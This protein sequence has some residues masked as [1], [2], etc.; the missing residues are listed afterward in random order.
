MLHSLSL[1]A[2]AVSLA[3]SLVQSG[4]ASQCQFAPGGSRVVAVEG[5]QSGAPPR[6]VQA[7][8]LHSVRK[9]IAITNGTTL[10]Q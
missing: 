7:T 8:A 9:S 10:A 6:S 4:Y 3:N 1:P 2:L 5:C